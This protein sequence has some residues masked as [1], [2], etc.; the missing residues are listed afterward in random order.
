M[1]NWESCPGVER[2]PLKVSGAWVFEGTRV[3]VPA[4]FESLKAGAIRK[5]HAL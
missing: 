1:A 4:L 3:P 2:H 5:P